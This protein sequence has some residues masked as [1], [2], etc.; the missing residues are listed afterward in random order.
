M[1]RLL[2]LLLVLAQPIHA[3][4]PDAR[5]A[6]FEGRYDDAIAGYRRALSRTPQSV[7]ATRG[8][9]R[10][11][12]Q[13]GRYD[14]AL[15]LAQSFVREQPNGADLA[16]VLG[17]TWTLIGL[18]AAAESAFVQAIEARASDALV[19]RLNRAVLWQEQGEW[20][21]A[22]R[23]YDGFIDVYNASRT[24]SAADIAAVAE[25]VHRLSSTDPGL[26]R[27][28]LRAY[29]EAMAADTL[30]LEPR[31]R[32]GQLF[33]E[34]FNGTDALDA[35]EGVLR[36]NPRHPGALLGL[37][38]TSRFVGEGK[39]MDMVQQALEVNPRFV[40]ARVFLAQLHAEAEDYGRA[41]E[42]VEK[43]LAVNPA[44]LEALAALAG[45][46]YL[47][48]DEQGWREAERRVLAINPRY[49]ALYVTLADLSARN[50]LY[51]AAARFGAR[52][53]AVDS[54]SW[55]GFA[56]LGI[57]QL[58]IG[59]VDS[60]RANLA[61]AF[62]GDPYDVWTRNTLELLDDLVEYPEVRTPRFRLYAAAA[63]SDVLSLYLGP[64]AEAAYDSLARRYGIEPPTPIR[65]EVFPNH[66]D[67]SVRTVGLVG[68]GALG[69][70][71]GPVI[72]MD[73]PSA[74]QAGG[75][76]WGSTF[77]HELAH[78]FHMALSDH[79]VPRWFTEGCAVY[80]ERRARPGWGADVTPQFLMA[81]GEGR[82]QPVSEL[83]DGFV[84]PAYPEQIMFSYYQA[85]LVCE[86]IERERGTA[87]LLA[88]LRGYAAGRSTEDL[89]VRV[90][91]LEPAALDDRFERYMRDRF[92]HAIEA[93]E[94]DYAEQL[95]RG[96]TLIAEERFEE[97]IPYLER[98]KALFP[99]YAGSDGPYH[100]LAAAHRELGRPERA[101]AELEAA[102]AI[103][104]DDYDAY[105]Q[106]AEILAELG[107]SEEAAAQLERAMYVSP[108]RVDAHRRLA[109]LAEAQ[110]RFE[111]AIRERRAVV[112]LD[113]INRAEAQY[114]L[115]NA[116]FLAGDMASARR[117]VL[118]S[119]EQAPGYQEAQE[120]LLLIHER[121]GQ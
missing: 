22:R 58:R 80:E 101:A 49:A 81:F 13:V 105:V 34:R 79:R 70:S 53:V 118:A 96:R 113:P 52:A 110:Q 43:A 82:L 36:R 46:R 47:E 25:A 78:S 45:V 100:L 21:R 35:F 75:F 94:G 10:A 11:L 104:A 48:G 28:A 97:A 16:N 8:L 66:A 64:L 90:L 55:R 60:G 87:A 14:E 111:V 76:N 77:W 69:V 18:R 108:F 92:G 29:D 89:V 37:A 74:Q 54:L 91:G 51:Y 7:D 83:N 24:L 31:V 67:F 44:S 5:R 39:P 114:R 26:A 88:F 85:S 57:N 50:R 109:E 9:V 32:V 86:M 30:E 73:S 116:H 102:V 2:P 98:A 41:L 95:S 17:E 72:A 68:L 93:L 12:R 23:A 65:V 63:E 15:A 19:A 112:A 42:E 38:R 56:V 4:A 106:L 84:R 33:L 1:M 40:A 119:L 117:T 59:R 99:E 62:A 103:N 27:D 121:E 107:R 3:Q 20:D 71:F 61:R 115:A 120:L 6:L